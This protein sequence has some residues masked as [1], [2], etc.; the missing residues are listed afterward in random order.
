MRTTRRRVLALMPC[1]SVSGIEYGTGLWII[2]GL[3]KK[4]SEM[5][6]SCCRKNGDI[7]QELTVVGPAK[8]ETASP[9][10]AI[11]SKPGTRRSRP[12]PREAVHPQGRV[13]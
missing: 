4:I 6:I 3:W 7:Q 8:A 13:L 5:S 1:I 10:S 2:Q 9:R 12:P 11:V